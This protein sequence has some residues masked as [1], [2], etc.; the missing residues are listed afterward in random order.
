[1]T[2]QSDTSQGA[3]SARGIATIA[4]HHP[5]MQ[6]DP[7]FVQGSPRGTT[8]DVHG[9]GNP[10]LIAIFDD[11]IDLNARLG[12]SVVPVVFGFMVVLVMVV[13][14][15]LVVAVATGTWR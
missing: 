5:T 9:G 6:P 15:A 13:V 1:M 11:S 4:I 14:V 12:R 2:G 8:H 3:E 10:R 7:A